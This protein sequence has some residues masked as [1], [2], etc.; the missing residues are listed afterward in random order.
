MASRENA[1]QS[2][3]I[4]HL[5]AAIN[6]DWLKKFNAGGVSMNTAS[7]LF[8]A[9]SASLNLRSLSLLASWCSMLVSS[10]WDGMIHRFPNSVLWINSW[11]LLSE[12]AEF[13][14]NGLNMKG[15]TGSMEAL[16]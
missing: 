1:S 13:E 4:R 2:K 8:N 16:K 11:M 10:G 5:E 15:L 3:G 6:A 12:P 9:S 14:K 7:K